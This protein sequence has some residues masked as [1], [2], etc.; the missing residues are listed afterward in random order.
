M[1]HRDG[2]SV[3]VS[4][5]ADAPSVSIVTV[6][7]KPDVVERCLLATLRRQAGA[8][9]EWIGVDNTAHAYPGAAEALNAGARR[10]RGEI[11]LFTHQDVSLYGEA[12]IAGLERWMRSL[13]DV[14]VAGVVGPRASDGMMVGYLKDRKAV[15]GHPLAAPAEVQTLDECVLAMRR[16]T[17]ERHPFDESIGGWHVYGVDACLRTRAAGLRSYALPLFIH[18]DSAAVNLAGLA[19]AHERVYRDHG[20]RERTIYT[21]CGVVASPRARLAGRVRRAYRRG[22]R[23]A[24]A[25]LRLRAT[26]DYLAL[27][28]GLAEGRRSVLVLDFF[29]GE[30]SA[31]WPTEVRAA[32]LDGKAASDT[33]VTHRV[34]LPGQ[35]PAAALGEGPQALLLFNLQCATPEQLRDLRG[36]LA[37]TTEG[38]WAIYPRWERDAV[39]ARAAG[40][41]WTTARERAAR[42]FSGPGPLYVAELR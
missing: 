30:P 36:A 10:A 32:A 27:L 23:G 6:F 31:T 9:F 39:R 15:A 16:A 34:L 28:Q 14:G 22:M 4:F 21:T 38:V 37:P 1:A 42:P 18:H 35:S 7:N 29:R 40:Q 33:A 19:E 24:A 41:G 25:A 3:Q 26:H 13:A 20:A 12:W 17:W 2:G 11:L 8:S 5:G